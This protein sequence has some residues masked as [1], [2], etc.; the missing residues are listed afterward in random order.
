[1]LPEALLEQTFFVGVDLG[2]RQDPSAAV[3]VERT[4]VEYGE[5]DPETLGRKKEY[6]L[7]VRYLE[8]FALETPYEDVVAQ[9]GH[10][11]RSGDLR[12]NCQAVVDATGV[13]IPVLEMMRRAH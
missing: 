10:L 7:A 5:R 3:V 4:R 6:R 2:Q 12:K 9:V 8:P 1:M 11:V 13:G